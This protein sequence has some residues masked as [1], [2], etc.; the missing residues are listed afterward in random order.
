MKA[1]C[2]F[3]QFVKKCRSQNIQN[4][5]LEGSD[6]ELNAILFPAI[7]HNKIDKFEKFLIL[8]SSEIDPDT[9]ILE[10]DETPLLV[11]FSPRSK[12]LRQMASERKI[13]HIISHYASG[14]LILHS[15][16]HRLLS[17][18]PIVYPKSLLRQLLH[19]DSGTDNTPPLKRHFVP[20]NP[21]QKNRCVD[22]SFRK[23]GVSKWW[24]TLFNAMVT[25]LYPPDQYA[26]IQ[27][28]KN[29]KDTVFLVKVRLKDPNLASRYEVVKFD[30][31]G[32]TEREQQNFDRIH[33]NRTSRH[34]YQLRHQTCLPGEFVGAVRSCAESAAELQ[35]FHIRTLRKQLEN[36]DGLPFVN[37][38]FHCIH[39]AIDSL[40]GLGRRNRSEPAFPVYR[41]RILPEV[42]DIFTPWGFKEIGLASDTD[43]ISRIQA[44]F[45]SIKLQSGNGEYPKAFFFKIA[46]IAPDTGRYNRFKIVLE[47]KDVEGRIFRL[48]WHNNFDGWREAFIR[49][50]LSEGRIVKIGGRIEAAGWFFKLYRKIGE[51]GIVTDISSV[52]LEKADGRNQPIRYGN[53][54]EKEITK[55]NEFVCS[56]FLTLKLT[57]PIRLKK[58]WNPLYLIQLCADQDDLLLEEATGPAHGDLNPD[59]IIIYPKE[60]GPHCYDRAA[61]SEVNPGE[62]EI[63]LIDLAS[64]DTDYPLAFDYVKLET[65]LKNHI[66]AKMVDKRL[67]GENHAKSPVNRFAEF[68]F[69]FEY[70]LQRWPT[71]SEV[72]ADIL[73]HRSEDEAQLFEI[74]KK[75]RTCG[76]ARYA[77]NRD[78]AA[79]LY[80]QQL[81]FYSIRTMNY[82]RLD[83]RAQLWAFIAALTAAD[84]LDL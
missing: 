22:T 1:N 57:I 34:L 6:K 56:P 77:N 26:Q 63:R 44:D 50:R 47:A 12:T 2:D 32:K 21:W 14:Y 53:S 35:T 82:Q 67:A 13:L 17:N 18:S 83:K 10:K 58:I 81:F 84:Y 49:K 33:G 76:Q 72:P 55:L 65:E 3:Y 68:A 74:I 9:P 60:E 16:D 4:S 66:L 25:C 54:Q 36:S 79:I 45:M 42:M 78:D 40:S 48:K 23:T 46:E 71:L 73:K 31:M 64:F 39:R 41:K 38:H 8:K 7:Y 61:K 11:A 52:A 51:L 24:E 37:Q 59:N 5:I 70:A 80:H 69:D 43:E 29:F 75:I 28:V 27:R 20:Q 15:V 19:E 62:P 30:S